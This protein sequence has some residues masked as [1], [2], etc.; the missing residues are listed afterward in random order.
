MRNEQELLH[1]W[2]SHVGG[3]RYERI[4]EVCEYLNIRYALGLEKSTHKIFYPLLY[5]GVIDFATDGKY[6]ITPMCVISKP[7]S[8]AIISNPVDKDGL[9]ETSFVGIYTTSKDKFDDNEQVYN[10]NLVS[11]LTV[12]P[13]VK[14]IVENFEHLYDYNPKEFSSGFGLKKRTTDNLLSYFIDINDKCYRVPHQ[15]NNP[16]SYNIAYCYDRIVR[17]ISNGIYNP[18]TKT[19]KLRLPHIPMLIFRT[20]M[21]ESLF[22]DK[23]PLVEGGY[24]TF[25]NINQKAYKELN[26][27]FCN[28][29]ISSRDE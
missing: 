18:T 17:N 11:I 16:D 22:N 24:Y 13:T 26:R 3:V 1:L 14:N 21:L 2:M 25:Y 6:Q 12:F 10:F 8:V 5:S 20:L 9:A 29:I 15:S 19:V 23:E 4:K 28:T 7:K 27:I